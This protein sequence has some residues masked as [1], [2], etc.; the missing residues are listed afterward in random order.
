[1][2][3]DSHCHFDDPRFDED[4]AAVW[5]RARAAGLEAMVLPAT[6]R[7]SWDVIAPLVKTYSGLYP[8]YGLHPMFMHEH[9]SAHI[10]ALQEWL[11]CNPCVAIGECGLDFWH[12]NQEQSQQEA[13]FERHLQIAA[14]CNKPVIVHARKS[15]DRVLFYLRQYPQVRGVVHSFS[16]SLQQA[17]QLIEQGFL[18]GIAATVGFERAK[19]LR[20]IV[21]RVPQQALLLE[22]DAPD[23]PGPGHRH[24]RNE[25]AW[26]RDHLKIMAQLR[27]E[28]EEELLLALSLNAKRLFALPQ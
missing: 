16:G 18:L 9:K 26:V 24:Q 12:S 28:P 6:T 27:A 13:L 17:E 4:R 5:S 8:A 10:E 22:S 3:I 21:A 25:P 15:L 20:S 7:A 23:Q 14:L 11:E 1:M 2:L 19:K